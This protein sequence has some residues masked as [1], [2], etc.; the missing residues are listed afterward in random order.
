ML[1]FLL[2]AVSALSI[3]LSGCAPSAETTDPRVHTFYYGWYANEET[4]GHLAHWNHRIMGLDDAG[5]FPGDGDI[6]ANFYPELGEY[7]SNDPA[8]ID[9]HMAM[10]HRTGIGVLVAS[11]WGPDTF[12][13]RGFPALLDGAERHGLQVAFHLEPFAGRDAATTREALR[14]LVDRYGDHPACYRPEAKGG[15]PVVYVYD[16]YLTPAED[17]ARLLQ[18][19]GEISIRGTELDAVMIGLWVTE[20]EGEFFTGGGFDGYYTYFGSDGFTWGSTSANWTTLAAFAR[21]RELLFVPCA[22]PG[23]LDT[24]IR[25]WNAATTRDREEGAYYDRMLA[26][27]IGCEPA[28]IGITSFNEWHEGTQIEPAVP[29]SLPGYVYEDYSP[30]APDYYLERT[31]Y[32]VERF[33]MVD[34]ALFMW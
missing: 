16:S 9:E 32:W 20:N 27:A 4:D 23:Y 34:I 30:L 19:D 3:L 11:W 29:R 14:Y 6:G 10:M 12:E 26:A 22:G 2:V 25:P 1:R 18:P 24:R 13:D 15:R 33:V 5:P 17:W 21:A 7:S 28:W 31:R 8:V